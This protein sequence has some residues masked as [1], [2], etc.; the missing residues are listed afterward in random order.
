MKN[1]VTILRELGI[2][3]PEDKEQEITRGVA[4]NYVTKAEHEKKITR[5]E[6][7]RDNFKTQNDDLTKSLKAFEGV[8]PEELKAQVADAVKKAAEA[9]KKA[10]DELARRDRNDM[11]DKALESVGFTSS[12]AK[13]DIVSR[14]KNENDIR[15]KDGQ[16]IGLDDYLNIYRKSDPDAFSGDKKPATFTTPNGGGETQKLTKEAIMAIKDSRERRQKIAENHE[17]FGY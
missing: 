11:I 13:K 7:E 1:V 16:L 3:I 2:E 15:V 8:N 10:N 4:E 12:Y 6:A 14:L 5:I 9:E 17:L